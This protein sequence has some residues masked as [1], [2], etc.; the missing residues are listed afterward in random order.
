MYVSVFSP[1]CVGLNV[2][3]TRI[4]HVEPSA[5]GDM[6]CIIPW[7]K[8]V[9]DKILRAFKL[10]LRSGLM[11]SEGRTSFESF[12]PKDPGVS[13]GRFGKCITNCFPLKTKLMIV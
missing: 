11:L 12:S 6:T 5:Y 4:Y 10:P 1:D 13:H 3:G 2:D 8:P 9:L 7:E